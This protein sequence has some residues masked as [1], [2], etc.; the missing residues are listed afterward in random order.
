MHQI[1]MAMSPFTEVAMAER[2]SNFYNAN[3]YAT[4]PPFYLR[5]D[6]AESGSLPYPGSS[7]SAGMPRSYGR[8][9]VPPSSQSVQ[10]EQEDAIASLLKLQLVNNADNQFETPGDLGY[11]RGSGNSNRAPISVQARRA[12]A[13]W[14]LDFHFGGMH[15]MSPLPEKQEEAV[16]SS[17]QTSKGPGA[18]DAQDDLDRVSSVRRAVAS[19]K[20]IPETPPLCSVCHQKSPVFGKVK[21]FTYAELQDATDNFSAENYL[22]KGGYGTVYKG[23]LKGGQLVAVKQ[24]KLSSSQGDEE[25]CAEVEVLSCAQHRN[26]VT[27]IGY[28]V[29]RHMRLLVYEYVCNGSLDR[30][31]SRK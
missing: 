26:L 1:P 7:H 22:A 13:N 25:F 8:S 23:Q 10:T 11:D 20:T 24:H 6:S 27:L 9:S 17:S 3:P 14:P 2:M 4:L 19:K 15:Q 31:L 16:L 5:N 18:D 21:K 12:D 28:C 29:E 30:H